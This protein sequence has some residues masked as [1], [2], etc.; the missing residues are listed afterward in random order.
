MLKELGLPLGLIEHMQT[1]PAPL[2]EAA[3]K[4]GLRL[5]VIYTCQ[6]SAWD[7]Q[8]THFDTNHMLTIVWDE[9][10]LDKAQDALAATIRAT[11]RAEANQSD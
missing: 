5:P 9:A 1:A 10:Q 3:A 6:K 4:G 2:D 7:S 11:L 8:K